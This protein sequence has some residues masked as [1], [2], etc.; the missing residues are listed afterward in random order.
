M[1]DVADVT[2]LDSWA[3]EEFG[4]ARLGDT[5]RTKRLVLVAHALG[6]RP[7]ASLPDAAQ[8]PAMLTATYRCFDTPQNTPAALR[9]PHL[10]ATHDRCSSVRLVLAVQDTSELDWSHHPA[11]TGLG[12]IHT[13]THCGLLMHTTMAFTPSGVP[14]GLLHQHVWARDPATFG[15]LP[16][17]RPFHEKESYRWVRALDGIHAARDA[18][19]RTRFV[20]VADAEA[21]IYDLFTAERHTGVDV[22]I[23][24]GQDRRVA[25]PAGALLWAAMQAGT[26]AGTRSIQV[27][28]RDGKPGRAAVVTVRYREVTIQPPS[29]A[30]QAGL[31][32]VTLWGVWAC[33]EQP[34]TGVEPVEWLLLTSIPVRT[35]RRAL[36]TLEWYCCRWGIEIWHKV[37]KSGCRIEARQ[38][39]TAERLQRCLVVFSVIA[40]R[41]QFATMVGRALP[42]LPCTAILDEAEWQALYCS[43]KRTTRLPTAIPELGVAVRWI[44]QLGGFQGRKGDGE[45]GVTVIWKGWQHLADLASMYTLFRPAASRKH[46][47]ND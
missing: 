12:P 31:E 13:K 27:A 4:A 37:L 9:A 42:Q 11:T 3:E 40:W 24:A 29:H 36:R 32:P 17:D 14:L 38:L 35:K 43:I 8:D 23:R 20:M 33:E 30:R 2:L 26:S 41:I 46:V 7:S 39:E 15:A 45:P 18:C 21:D 1:I 6:Q 5:R 16:H 28:P 34:P 47:G 10:A 19:P 44:A 25:G 22:L